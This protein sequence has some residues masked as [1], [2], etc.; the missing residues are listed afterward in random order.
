M[1]KHN[2]PLNNVVRHYDAS[3]KNCPPCSMAKD[4]LEGLG[5]EFKEGIGRLTSNIVKLMLKEAL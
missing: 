5:M 4:N 3:R 2:I 1:N